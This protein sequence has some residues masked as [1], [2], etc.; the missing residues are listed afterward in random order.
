MAPPGARERGDDS[1]EF[2]DT[3]ADDHGL[4]APRVRYRYSD[5]DPETIE[6][7]K[8]AVAEAGAAVGIPLDDSPFLLPAG[9][10]PHHQGTTRM[11]PA[12][13]GTSVR[14]SHSRV[15]N[16]RGCGSP[17]TTSSRRPP[18]AP[19][20]DVRRPRRPGRPRTPGPPSGHGRAE[21]TGRVTAVSRARVRAGCRR[22][23][24]V[25]RG[26]W[27]RWCASSPRNPVRKPLT[28]PD[29]A[30]SAAFTPALEGTPTAE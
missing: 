7:A 30:W 15:W 20:P 5:R 10:S 4:P 13:D 24:A 3:A 21:H 23:R 16:T 22:S 2:S 19:H 28:G 11:G 25:P 26:P 27:R 6:Q 9:G 29:T 8:K 17:A 1:E 12:H 18:P 14:D